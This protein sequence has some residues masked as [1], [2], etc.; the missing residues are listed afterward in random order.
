MPDGTDLT[1][2]VRRYILVIS[3]LFGF[4]F[5][6]LLYI[7]VV[8][9]YISQAQLII[10]LLR[11]IKDKVRNKVTSLGEAVKVSWV[12]RG[13]GVCSRVF[14]LPRT[15]ITRIASCTSSTGSCQP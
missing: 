10:Y 5:F 7:S 8:I 11:S 2:D 14:L 15:F 1:Y 13:G 4:V 9:Y 6:D 12:R 3:A